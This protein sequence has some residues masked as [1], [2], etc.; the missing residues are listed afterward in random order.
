MQFISFDNT[1]IPVL[2]FSNTLHHFLCFIHAVSGLLQSIEADIEYSGRIVHIKYGHIPELFR[3]LIDKIHAYQ[4][5]SVPVSPLA[6]VA[7]PVKSPFLQSS[8]SSASVTSAI[9]SKYIS[10][11]LA[12]ISGIS[13]SSAFGYILNADKL[14]NKLKTLR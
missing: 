1:V 3:L 10:A 2:G 8:D 9:R 14:K 12:E 7:N 11:E 13:V 4:F 5:F 6:S